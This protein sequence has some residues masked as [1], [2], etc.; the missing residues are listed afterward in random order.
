MK[1]IKT[2]LCGVIAMLGVSGQAG[3]I[4]LRKARI[5]VVNPANRNQK[6][7]AEE[8]EKHLLLIAGERKPAKDGFEFVIG[9][10][11][12]KGTA[13]KAWESHAMVDGGTLYF[14]G[15]DGELSENR[16]RG[17]VLAVFGFLDE[18]L[19]VKW[20]RP[21]DEGILYTQKTRVDIPDDWKYRFY[22]PL[23]RSDIRIYAAPKKKNMNRGFE[24][25]DITPKELKPTLKALQDEYWDARVWQWRMRLLTR[26][27]YGYGHAFMKW[28]DRFYGTTNQHF[29]AMWTGKQ[30]GHHIK[31]RGKWIHLCHSNPG[32]HDQ[33]IR[34]W[35][36]AGTNRYL[37]VCA[38]DSRTT[39]CRC[40]GCRA[41]DADKP[42]EDFLN[43]KSDRQVWLWNQL[44][45]KA[46][47]IRPDV[48]IIAYSYTNYRYPP[49]R[50]RIEYP[51]NMIV[52]VV[53]S[54][55]DDSNKIIQGWKDMGMK[56]YFVRPNYLCSKVALPR[57]LE[58]YFFEDFKAN[59]KLG[60]IGVDHDNWRRFGSMAVMF[61]FYA[62][63]RVIANPDLTFDEM[64]RDYLSQF[65]AAAGDMKEYYS[66][67]R[68]RGEAAR[69][70]QDGNLLVMKALDDGELA[71]IGYKAHSMADLNGD[72]AVIDK[73]LARTGLTDA[74]RKRIMEV[75][76][77]VEHGML[78]MDFINKGYS[79]DAGAAFIE[80][81]DRLLEFRLRH[82]SADNDMR[83]E[84]RR[85]FYD[86]RSERP[87]WN[88]IKE[89]RAVPADS[90]AETSK[91]S[92]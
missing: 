79:K 18:L 16:G 66:R 72:I 61:E 86:G 28:N 51:D 50:W 29:M 67:V 71:L 26:A 21:G 17:S 45:K 44:A 5:T 11:A 13:A 70:A 74:E 48:K 87:L 76:L 10:I 8:L 22:P 58:R 32:V 39:H 75:K 63:A 24:K 20:V 82:G 62:L 7:A 47:K 3:E 12:P 49:R 40:E 43:H 85:F 34:D 90:K 4:D 27:T 1:R 80:A 89:M 92:R 57:G 54:L 78:T 69:A 9:R 77:V 15:D 37:N 53:P 81:A 83:E 91:K 65:G 41:L 56:E 2:L 52:G 88:R 42:G 38:T 68:I 64:E 84:W 6:I 60:M 35:C 30:R 33:I 46:I 25:D 36:E 73:A 31:D 14:W 23:E 55:Y 59:A 19:G